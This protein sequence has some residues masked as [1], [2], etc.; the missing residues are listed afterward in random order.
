[1]KAESRRSRHRRTNGA[2]LTIPTRSTKQEKDLVWV[3]WLALVLLVSVLMVG[4]TRAAASGAA[5]GAVHGGARIKAVIVN[6]LRVSAKQPALRNEHELEW[7]VFGLLPLYEGLNDFES[8]Q[9]LV[10]LE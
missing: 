9:S 2:S 6:Y 3:G 10:D 4:G 8:L 1:M 7:S 5:T